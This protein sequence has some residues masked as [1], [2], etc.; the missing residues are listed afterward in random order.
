MNDNRPTE[1]TLDYAERWLRDGLEVLRPAFSALQT[2]VDMTNATS[3]LE[4]LRRQGVQATATH[5]LV[6]ATARALRANPRLHQVVAGIRR[7]RPERVDIGLSVTGETFVAPVMVIEGADRKQSKISSK[8]RHGERRKFARPIRPC[9]AR[10]GVGDDWYPLVFSGGRCFVAC[11]R[12]RR[13]AGRVR[14]RSRYPLFRSIG[15]C[16][17]HSVRRACLSPVRRDPGWWR[18]MA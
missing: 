5:L 11:S 9:C 3:R 4:R 12:A 16:H 10:S 2:T 6:Q 17:R 1:E 15:R 14:G 7:Q 13:F 18:L 8:R